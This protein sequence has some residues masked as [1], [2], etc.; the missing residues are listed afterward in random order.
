MDETQKPI[1]VKYL[2]LIEKNLNINDSNF[3]NIDKFFRVLIRDA[4]SVD[5]LYD[6]LKF[7]NDYYSVVNLFESKMFLLNLYMTEIDLFFNSSQVALLARTLVASLNPMYMSK[8]YKE[9]TCLLVE[10]LKFLQTLKTPVSKNRKVTYFIDVFIDKFIRDEN[11]DFLIDFTK[12][13]NEPMKVGFRDFFE[14][15]KDLSTIFPLNSDNFHLIELNKSLLEKKEKFQKS[16]NE[17]AVLEKNMAV[18]FAYFSNFNLEDPNKLTFKEYFNAWSEFANYLKKALITRKLIQKSNEKQEL[19]PL[20]TTATMIMD[21][22]SLEHLKLGKK[23]TQWSDKMEI[24][25]ESEE[26]ENFGDVSDELPGNVQVLKQEFVNQK[27]VEKN[28]QDVLEQQKIEKMKNKLNEI[29]IKKRDLR[30]KMDK[31]LSFYDNTR[32]I[33]PISPTDINDILN[34]NIDDEMIKYQQFAQEYNDLVVDASIAA[35]NLGLQNQDEKIALDILKDWKKYNLRRTLVRNAEKDAKNYDVSPHQL[36]E[37]ANIIFEHIEKVPNINYDKFKEKKAS[38][39]FS[40]ENDM[41]I[42]LIYPQITVFYVK[43]VD[44]LSVCFNYPTI[45]NLVH[46]Y[47][48][49]SH[50][51]GPLLVLAR[52]LMRP[53]FINSGRF[54]KFLKSDH[55]DRKTDYG[56][57]MLKLLANVYEKDNTSAETFLHHTVLKRL[58]RNFYEQVVN[59][60]EN[61]DSK[62]SYFLKLKVEESSTGVKEPKVVSILEDYTNIVYPLYLN[63]FIS[64]LT[65]SVS[66]T[67]S[68]LSSDKFFIAFVAQKLDN[69]NKFSPHKLIISNFKL[70][71]KEDLKKFYLK[72]TQQIEIFDALLF[73]MN[74]HPYVT[75]EVLETVFQNTF[76]QKLKDDKKYLQECEKKFMGFTE[77]FKSFFEKYIG[78]NNLNKMINTFYTNCTSFVILLKQ[79]NI[80]DPFKITLANV[81]QLAVRKK[82]TE[83]TK[84]LKWIN[85]MFRSIEY[86]Y[87]KIAAETNQQIL[88]SSILKDFPLGFSNK[89]YDS[90]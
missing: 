69:V 63:M 54:K 67:I 52:N 17:V 3:N 14:Y 42:F 89:K 8:Y 82:I 55:F 23:A 26:E 21:N 12:K 45:F 49:D 50:F 86:L 28:Q 10:D 68:N 57:Y 65:T 27:K 24:D 64:F 88:R 31:I 20:F 1:F 4:G 72:Y 85:L 51:K 25:S 40:P 15:M 22:A 29:E 76:Y 66:K 74:N 78:R 87:I 37:V 36:I 43:N 18:K 32:M 19:N 41:S 53:V 16:L 38:D 34:F 56:I 2:E 73:L 5:N 6:K 62:L 81:D 35:S 48:L 33:Q 70:A 90:Y 44:L 39:F 79:N 77:I 59:S 9:K 11:I 80:T 60:P 58:E 75:L 7:I 30:K 84:I 71:D 13:F 61:V 47:F 46:T 83:I